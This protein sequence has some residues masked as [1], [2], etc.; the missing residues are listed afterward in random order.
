VNGHLTPIVKLESYVIVLTCAVSKKM[1]C[2]PSSIIS[3]IKQFVMSAVPLNWWIICSLVSVSAQSFLWWYCYACPAWRKRT[4]WKGAQGTLPQKA[5]TTSELVVSW[6]MM[7]LGLWH[8]S[9]Y[10]ASLCQTMC[11]C[12]PVVYVS[13]TT[14][15]SNL[16]TVAAVQLLWCWRDTFP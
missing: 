13:I 2:L 5:H 1:A 15:D 12:L 16:S 11:W 9:P 4:G 14:C 10:L 3:S 7:P 6:K 8:W